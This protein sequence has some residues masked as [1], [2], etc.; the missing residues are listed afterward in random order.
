MTLGEYLKRFGDNQQFISSNLV[1]IL[2]KEDG[3]LYRVDNEKVFN[4]EYNDYLLE[5]INFNDLLVRHE[6]RIKKV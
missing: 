1:V 4:K 6:L 5:S 2:E 3:K